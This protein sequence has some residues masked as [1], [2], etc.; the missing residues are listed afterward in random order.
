MKSI[1]NN[2]VVYLWRKMY[3]YAQDRR[4]NIIAATTMF[5]VA[6]IADAAQPLI[7]GY[8]LNYI[9]KNGITKENLI[10]LFFILLLFLASEVI[11]WTFW[12]PAR[13]IEQKTAFITKKNY[14]EY[15]LRGT[16]ALPLS[17]H[18]DH[19]S[20]NTIDKIEKGTSAIFSFSEET[21]MF[22][23]AFVRLV[24]SLG[25]LIYLDLYAS[26]MVI[27]ISAFIFF[28]MFIYDKKLI[29]GY[30][31]VNQL[32]NKI[33]AKVYDVISNITTVII[34]R[35]EHLVFKA[36]SKSID[37]PFLQFKKNIINNEMKWFWAAT[38]G[39]LSV[40][41]TIGIYLFSNVSK[42][43][44]ILIGFVYILYS[45]ASKVRE[46]FFSFAQLYNDAVKWRSNISNAEEISADFLNTTLL[47]NRYLPKN[48]SLIEIKDLSFSYHNETDADLHLDDVNIDFKRGEK[49]AVIGESGGGKTTFLKIFRGLY[50]PKS[51]ILCIN[52][53]E[54]GDDLNI[55]SDSISLIPQDPEIF[56]TTIRENITLGVDYEDREIRKFT[57]MA[58]FTEVISRL[59]KGLESSIVEKGVNLSGGEKQRLALARGLLASKDKDIILLDEPTSSVDFHNELK[60]YENIFSSLPDKTIISSIHRLHLL[61]L[62]DDIFFFKD[63]KIVAR[64]NLEQLKEKSKDFK[65]LWA[66]YIKTQNQ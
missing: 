42:G 7:F 6:N 17:W 40:I 44:I 47:E 28:I 54:C 58:S 8:F 27:I 57:D 63:G 35:I 21:F 2:P 26:F 62:F 4:K 65:K 1:S 50:L 9:Q 45:Y 11:F 43:N 37:T 13:I 39:Q 38:L 55:I 49:I 12:A 10:N 51:I 30:R 29:P 20:G 33:S 53:K 32:E 36:I 23:Q 19:H 60:I 16:M 48:W 52:D 41:L 66:K 59:P 14:K 5:I 18:T 56:S 64:G 22:I 34:L 61:S 24:I 31:V 25:A 3:F 46:T 15:L